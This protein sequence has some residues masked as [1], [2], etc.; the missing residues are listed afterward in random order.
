MVHNVHE[1]RSKSV[2]KVEVP[3]NENQGSNFSLLQLIDPVNELVSYFL[4][5]I[6]LINN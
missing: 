5:A 2:F 1:E 3:A 6:K 4:K